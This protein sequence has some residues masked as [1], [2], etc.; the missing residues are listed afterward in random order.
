MV[1]RVAARRRFVLPGY[2]PSW[3]DAYGL[4]LPIAI[5]A[6]GLVLLGWSRAMAHRT[7]RGVQLLARVRG[8][9]EFLDAP[10]RTG[11]SACHPTPP[12]VPAVA[13]SLGVT[14]RWIFNF[15]GVKVDLRLVHGPP[16]RSR[17][18]A[19]S[20]GSRSSDGPRRRPI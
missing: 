1:R 9:Q 2:W 15:D 20:P 18:T 14:E 11:S 12:P 13:I 4:V 19:I 16:H 5:G 7:W 8:F 17:S 3:L 6:S 10:R